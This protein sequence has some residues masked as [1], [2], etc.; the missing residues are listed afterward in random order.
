MFRVQQIH[1][2]LTRNINR[3]VK[4]Y[5]GLLVLTESGSL[6]FLLALILLPLTIAG[7]DEHAIFCDLVSAPSSNSNHVLTN[8]FCNSSSPPLRYYIYF[9]RIV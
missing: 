6:A 8:K 5:T 3:H 4:I 2:E 1:A 7:I 9:M